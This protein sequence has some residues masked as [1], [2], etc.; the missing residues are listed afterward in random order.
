M[1]R[2]LIICL[3]L[4]T[5]FSSFAQLSEADSLRVEAIY[6][7]S[8]HEYQGSKMNM[9]Y[10]DSCVQLN[11]NMAKAWRDLGTPYLKRG[12]FA[13]W[14][15]YI[16]KA[17]ALNPET[18]LISRG[19]CRYKF[20]RDYEGALADLKEVIRITGN[21]SQHTGDGAYNLYV[22]LAL[23]E[24]G[25]GHPE[26]ALEYLNYGIDSVQKWE[27]N[28]PPDVYSYVHR[29]ALK[30]QLK[31]YKGAMKDLITQEQKYPD[32]AE[33]SY[34]KGII[35]LAQKK[36]VAAVEQFNIADKRLRAGYRLNDVYCEIPDSIYP[37]D[38]TMALL[39]ATPH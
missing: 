26:A 6:K 29:A 12:D 8:M 27:P 35:L 30:I 37:E 15:W 10:L 2:I 28:R 19:W 16:N 33:T 32:L 39:A 25:L 38:I 31:D 9:L 22:V 11:P 5:A 1:K 3:V 13:T 24:R 4:G 20:M 36:A 21:G 34:Y 14:A 17:V 18:F 7:R 23:C